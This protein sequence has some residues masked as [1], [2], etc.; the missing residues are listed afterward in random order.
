[1]E[2]CPFGP[3]REVGPED[4]VAPGRRAQ[5]RP[6]LGRWQDEFAI[7]YDAC[8]QAGLADPRRV[9][10]LAMWEVAS[11]LG[12][13]RESEWPEDAP[14]SADTARGALAAAEGRDRPRATDPPP[15]R[16][17]W[18]RMVALMKSAKKRTG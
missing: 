8:A 9:D 18:Q 16:E 11:I 13:N 6:L 3:W 15:T 4:L 1:M 5:P 2:V 17:E 10:D 12:V 7:I 14:I